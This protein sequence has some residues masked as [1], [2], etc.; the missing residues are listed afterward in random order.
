MG[1]YNEIVITHVLLNLPS[2]THARAFVTR[3]NYKKLKCILNDILPVR[4]G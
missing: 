3:A 2:S 4:Q 1:I